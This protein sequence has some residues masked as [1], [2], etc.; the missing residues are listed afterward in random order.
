MRRKLVVHLAATWDDFHQSTSG[1]LSYHEREKYHLPLP[2]KWAQKVQYEDWKKNKA[3]RH[4]AYGNSQ[5]GSKNIDIECTSYQLPL[6]IN[7]YGIKFQS[8]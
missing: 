3:E 4:N 2:H 8:R 7:Y 5:L 1:L 6:R